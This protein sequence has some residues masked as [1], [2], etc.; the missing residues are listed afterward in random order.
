MARPNYPTVELSPES[1]RRLQIEANRRCGPDEDA[2]DVARGL[3]ERALAA[4]LG[5]LEAEDIHR[6]SR[7]CGCVACKPVALG[8]AP[9]LPAV[10][11]AI[12]PSPHEH[13]FTVAAGVAGQA[14]CP[15]GALAPIENDGAHL[16]IVPTERPR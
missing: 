16:L 14:G 5:Q 3:L 12:E 10:V 1:A 6:H 8:S 9:E 15:C 2:R 11:V 7:F 13:R 4:V